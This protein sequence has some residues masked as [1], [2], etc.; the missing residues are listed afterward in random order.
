MADR[1]CVHR[2]IVE[3]DAFYGLTPAAQALYLHLTAAA[4][5]DGFINSAS[6]IASKIT[7][8]KNALALLVQR[9]FLL[10]YEDIYVVKHWRVANS[11]KNDRKK[12]LAYPSIAQEL[13]VKLTRA[14]TDHPVDGCPTLYDLKF[15]GISESKA[16]SRMDSTPE[17]E[18]NPNW[19]TNRTEPNRTEPNRTEP[20][21]NA[22]GAGAGAFEKFWCAYPWDQDN[23][24]DKAEALRVWQSMHLDRET[25][26][27]IM[28]SLDSWKSSGDWTKNGGQYIPRPAN[29]LRGRWMESPKA[30]APSDR[31]RTLDSE[32]ISAIQRL[33]REAEG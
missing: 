25:V 11:L 22:E 17:S 10:K 5:D 12:P 13:W 6:S 1:R 18:W 24:F 31:K 16:D 8:G 7:G 26:D 28:L 19:N 20:N 30:P 21:R 4:D 14:Y 32:E 3:S 27:K 33:L 2:K 29:W 23:G 15:G 9:R